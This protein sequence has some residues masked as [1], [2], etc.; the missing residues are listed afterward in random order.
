MIKAIFPLSVGM[1]DISIE[2][3][4]RQN[5]SSLAEILVTFCRFS[6]PILPLGVAKSWDNHHNHNYLRTWNF[7]DGFPNILEIEISTVLQRAG[8]T[9]G[10]FPVTLYGFLETFA[11][12]YCGVAYRVHTRDYSVLGTAYLLLE[13]VTWYYY[14]WSQ[15]DVQYPRLYY[16]VPEK[17][18][19]SKYWHF[20]SIFTMLQRSEDHRRHDDVNLRWCE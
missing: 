4:S 6:L 3:T 16:I 15:T 18:D 5:F 13:L 17:F 12:T 11:Q 9:T 2:I 1:I 14:V 8:E 19:A 10:F 20:C 7:V